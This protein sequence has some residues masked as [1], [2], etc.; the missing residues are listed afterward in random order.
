MLSSKRRYRIEFWVRCSLGSYDGKPFRFSLRGAEVQLTLPG[1][2]DQHRGFV[3]AVDLTRSALTQAQVDSH[4]LLVQVLNLISLEFKMSAFVEKGVRSQ[5][6]QSGEMRHCAIYGT[7]KR[8]RSLF[9]MQQQADEIQ[10]LLGVELPPDVPA[11]IYWLR[12]SYQAERAPDAFLFAW[13][14]LERLVGDEDRQA[15]CRQCGKPVVCSEHGSHTYR[16][17]SASKIKELLVRYEVGNPAALSGLRNGLVHGGLKFTFEKRVMMDRAVPLLWK[18]VEGELEQRLGMKT[19]VHT[20]GGGRALTPT[21][22]IH[23]E[24][25]TSHPTEAF[26]PDCPN[27]DDVQEYKE[28]TR[29]GSK[30]WKIVKLLAW[31]PNW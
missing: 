20:P 26:P 10:R 12:W 1:S 16:S 22:N 30:H 19:V 29:K 15:I 9:L 25:Q 21:E 5:V 8:S 2:S 27:Y 6:E 17:V 11:A 28:L 18:V 23:C 7:E 3:A 4:D 31:P 24:Y 13:M 14:A